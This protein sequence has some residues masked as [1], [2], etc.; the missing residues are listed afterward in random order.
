MALILVLVNKSELAE[1]SD[2]TYQVL[3]G[4]GTPERSQTLE[5]GVVKGHLRSK[6]WELLIQKFLKERVPDAKS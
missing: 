5:R 4:D 3:I 2:Y 1:R 6:G